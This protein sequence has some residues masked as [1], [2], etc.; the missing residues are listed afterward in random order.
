MNNHRNGSI[1]LAGVCAAALGASH[2]LAEPATAETAETA[3]QLGEIVVTATRRAESLQDVPISVTAVTAA[4]LVNQQIVDV[5]DLAKIVPGMQVKPALTPEEITVTVRGV[6]TLIP[7]IN[8]DPG[9][10]IYIDGVYNV[11]NAG[12]NTAMVDMDQAEVLKGP[13]GTLFGRNTIGGAINITTTKPTDTWGGY[14]DASTG[15]YGAW[16]TTG[17]INVPIDPGVLDTRFVYQHMQNNG[18]GSNFYAGDAN[19]TLM[20]DYYRGTV[21][22]VPVEGW[23]VLGSAYYTSAFGFGPPTKLTYVSE[24]ATL[25]PGLPPTNFLI[26]FLS[27]HPGDLL[28]NYLIANNWQN[29]NQDLS[30]I[31]NL[32]QYG[33]TG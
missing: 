30:N 31:Y 10:G 1:F 19:S 11:V 13:Q 14:V 2:A 22:Y 4:E 7:S 28:S 5:T 6:S 27:G 18:Y 17:V 23:E 24:T 26:P 32:K 29:G 16:S 25:G 9:V 15:V 21:K 33:Y 3:G 20:E 8:Q 12:S